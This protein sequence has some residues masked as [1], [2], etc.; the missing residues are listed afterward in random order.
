M[1]SSQ[2]S[3]LEPLTSLPEGFEYRADSISPDEEAA[4]LEH[5]RGLDFKEYEFHGY[6]GKRRVVSFGLHYGSNECAVSNTE[7]I[8][9]FLLNLR[10]KGWRFRAA[11]SL[12]TAAS[13]GH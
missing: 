5:L 13:F 10:Q 11:C 8:P 1:S 12:R 7:N 2:L 3:F 9:G 4:F 6:L